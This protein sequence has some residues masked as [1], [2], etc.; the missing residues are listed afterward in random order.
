MFD[1]DDE[2]VNSAWCVRQNF[3]T[4]R[5]FK[6]S[7]VGTC[8]IFQYG[9]QPAYAKWRKHTI[10]SRSRAIRLFRNEN[11][12]QPRA[13]VIRVGW[14]HSCVTLLNS[15]KFVLLLYYI[16]PNRFFA[17][18]CDS[19]S[20]INLNNSTRYACLLLSYIDINWFFASNSL[21]KSYNVLLINERFFVFSF[22][23]TKLCQALNILY[24]HIW[25]N[26]TQ[27]SELFYKWLII[28]ERNFALLPSVLTP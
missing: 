15:R 23:L 18:N 6:G 16:D 10:S 12:P 14:S 26:Y 22:R 28:H 21:N 20:H 27:I 25:N 24:R 11:R 9:R 5:G 7:D 2:E 13:R 17:S 8:E 3:A 1:I 4:S 19:L